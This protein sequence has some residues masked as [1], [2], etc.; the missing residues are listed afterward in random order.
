MVFV[1]FTC[2][3]VRIMPEF[4]AQGLVGRWIALV[5]FQE[6]RVCVLWRLVSWLAIVCPRGIFVWWIE[7]VELVRNALCIIGRGMGL[8]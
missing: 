4:G 3:V 6:S 1:V 8:L 2:R 5:C 7:C